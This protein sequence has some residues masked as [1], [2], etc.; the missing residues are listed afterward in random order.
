MRP[1]IL[2]SRLTEITI[3]LQSDVDRNVRSLP[4]LYP[5]T[6]PLRLLSKLSVPPLQSSEYLLDNEIEH[7]RDA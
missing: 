3:T 5:T 2:S 4:D 6:S 7:V 1:L